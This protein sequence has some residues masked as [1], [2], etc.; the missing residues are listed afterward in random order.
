MIPSLQ[1]FFDADVI[2]AGSASPAGAS[3]ALLQIAELRLITGWTTPQVLDE[4]RRNLRQKLPQVLPIFEVLWPRCLQMSSDPDH[5]DLDQ[6]AEYAHVKDRHVVAA[7]LQIPTHWLV[8]FNGRHFYSPPGL[9]VLRPHDAIQR[10]RAVIDSLTDDLW[11]RPPPAC[12][13]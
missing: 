8:T 7:A 2:I 3:H 9:V 6:V 10:L 4:V 13:R 12:I 1:V 5:T 11:L